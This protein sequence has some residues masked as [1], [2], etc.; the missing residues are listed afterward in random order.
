M[1]DWPV[2]GSDTFTYQ[3]DGATAAAW[4][5]T[6][7]NTTLRIQPIVSGLPY[8]THTFTLNRVTV[9]TWTPFIVKFIVYQP[10]T[11]SIPATALP[12]AAYNVMAT[13]SDTTAGDNNVS[14]GVLR[15]MSTRE[16]V[17]VGGGWTV[18]PNSVVA[19]GWYC[20]TE[21]NDE[22]VQYTF[23][24]TGA[25]FRLATG[26]AG[27]YTAQFT[28]TDAANP[29]GTTNFSSYSTYFNG[30]GL[31]SF[32]AATGLL[33]SSGSAASNVVSL[34][35]LALGWHIIQI[36]K[37]SG[38]SP[39]R[40]YLDAVDIITPI[41]SYKSN[42]Y[43]DLQN[44]LTVGSNSLTDSRATTPIMNALPAAKAWAQAVGVASVTTTATTPIPLASMSV[45]LKT[46]GGPLEMNFACI[47]SHSVVGELVYFRF[48]VDGVQ[49]GIETG[50]HE[51]LAGGQF[52]MS[53]EAITPVAAGFHKVDAYWYTTN[54]TAS[55]SSMRI[56]TVRE[57]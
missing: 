29:S 17:Y 12:L 19:G 36:K 21:G 8:G 53:N 42:L 14:P 20:Y 18:A 38:A 44:T 49:V 43:A 2:G 10:K 30:T 16:M 24:G 6:A 23:F 9:A 47:Y 37:K 56:L 45:T 26:S 46:S 33:T 5:N 7:G 28:L 27:A 1:Y 55:C 50:A 13:Y 34:Y 3:I 25:G 52:T 11:P 15:K 35:G 32:P 40:L 31:T 54:P 39:I 57:I 4:P 41:H 22:Y 48:Y 51:V